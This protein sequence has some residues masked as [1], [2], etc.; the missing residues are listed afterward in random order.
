MIHDIIFNSTAALLLT[1]VGRIRQNR[2]E[3][4][5]TKMRMDIIVLTYHAAER[6][7]G[8]GLSP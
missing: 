8:R 6:R 5:C 7:G 2:V 4:Y 1:D 3:D